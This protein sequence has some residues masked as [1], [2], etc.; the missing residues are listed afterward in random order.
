LALGTT[1]AASSGEKLLR[2]APWTVLTRV[3]SLLATVVAGAWAFRVLSPDDFGLLSVL[4]TAALVLA[5][6]ASGGLDRTLWRFY[7]EV[8]LHHGAAAARALAKRTLLAQAALTL[9]VAL[10]VLL[11]CSPLLELLGAKRQALAT[12]GQLTRYAL[13]ALVVSTVA[14]QSLT[15]W[16]V[17]RFETSAVTRAALLRSGVWLALTASAVA[18]APQVLTLV[19]AEAL[20]LLVA[21]VMLWPRE[22]A[23]GGPVELSPALPWSRQ[24]KLAAVYF[25]SGI[26]NF[27]VQRQSEVFFLAKYHG[28]EASGLYDLAYSYPQLALELVPLATGPVVVSALA[29]AYARDPATLVRSTQRYFRL[30]I[31]ASLPLAALGAAWADMALELLMGPRAAAAGALARVFSLVHVVPLLFLPL[32]AALS[33][34]ERAHRVIVL[35]PIQAAINLGL[36][37]L[38]IPQYGLYGALLAVVGTL[39]FGF[40][41]TLWLTRVVLGHTGFPAGYFVRVFAASAC[42]SVGLLARLVFEG[43]AA[44][45]LGLPL[46]AIGLVLGLRA[47]RALGPDEMQILQKLRGR[48]MGRAGR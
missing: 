8:S 47:F 7:P 45:A 48:L 1:I 5:V 17:S 27:V 25:L 37:A 12:Q 33:T 3:L 46:S 26:V 41:A 2:A 29:E 36:D 34:A 22:P 21:A 31:V 11:F 19:S 20:A 18:W 23:V 30:L 13:A 16:R 40:P 14:Y 39:A 42:A 44:M 9:A 28:L 32:S 6:V 43:P 38:L 10:G 15:Q 35:G 24:A 4:R